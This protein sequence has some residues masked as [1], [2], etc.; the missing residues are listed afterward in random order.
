MEAAWLIRW[1]WDDAEE[2]I[3]S[4]LLSIQPLERTSEEIRRLVEALYGAFSYPAA[5][6][7][8]AAED[9]WAAPALSSVDRAGI[10]GTRIVCGSGRRIEA[11][12]ARDVEIIDDDGT[13]VVSWT[14]RGDGG[15]IQKTLPLGTTPPEAVQY[16]G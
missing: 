1:N 15:W 3:D 10:G 13:K 2:A 8:A 5:T 6:L 12:E 16:A 14:E 4:P 7:V 9:P 11:C